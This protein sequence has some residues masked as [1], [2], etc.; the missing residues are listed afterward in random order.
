[1]F[2]AAKNGGVEERD[3]GQQLVAGVAGVVRV[4]K[5][6][7]FVVGGGAFEHEGQEFNGPMVIR[8]VTDDLRINVPAGV[9]GAAV[10]E[11]KAA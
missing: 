1:M 2:P 3:F 9:M 10:W 4:P 7:L 6:G 11:K 8:A 5:G